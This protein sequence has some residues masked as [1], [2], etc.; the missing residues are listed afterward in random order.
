MEMPVFLTDISYKRNRR[1]AKI[2]SFIIF[3]QHNLCL[4]GIKQFLFTFYC[5]HLRGNFNIVLQGFRQFINLRRLNKWFIPLDVYDVLERLIYLAQ[6]LKTS[7][8]ATC[9]IFTR[10]HRLSAEIDYMI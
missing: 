4:A 3:I 1:A 2:Q 10:H 6:R 5:D 9:M 7:V 8:G